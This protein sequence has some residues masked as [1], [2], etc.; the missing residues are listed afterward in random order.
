MRCFVFFFESQVQ[1]EKSEEKSSVAESKDDKDK[2]RQLRYRV[3]ALK[4]HKVEL[5]EEVQAMVK[6]LS[7]KSGQEETKLLHPAVSQHGRAKKEVQEAQSAKLQLHSAWKSV[8]AQSAERWQT[9]T[10]HHQAVHGPGK[11]NERQIVG[12]PQNCMI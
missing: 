1:S 9:Y 11:A 8:L 10:K 12:Q 6:D 2:E 5:P 4:K 3:A 7:V